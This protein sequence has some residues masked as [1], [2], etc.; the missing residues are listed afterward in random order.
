MGFRVVATFVQSARKSLVYTSG[1]CFGAISTM[2]APA[3]K[4]FSSFNGVARQ[5]LVV[6]RTVHTMSVPD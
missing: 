6:R 5:E 1:N 2:S 3:A 4:A